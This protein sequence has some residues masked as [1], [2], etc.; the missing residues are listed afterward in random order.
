MHD[1]LANDRY[2]ELSWGAKLLVLMVFVFC[3]VTL[4]NLL[5]YGKR[6]EQDRQHANSPETKTR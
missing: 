4:Y 5:K 6:L 2:A 1:H 3:S